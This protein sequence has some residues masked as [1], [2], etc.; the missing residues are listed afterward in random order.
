MAKISVITGTSRGIGKA[1]ALELAQRGLTV[2]AISQNENPLKDLQKLNPDKINIIPAD[3][4]TDAGQAKIQAALQDVKIDYLINNAGIIHPIG[5]LHHASNNA[6]RK[7]FETNLLAPIFLT[8]SLISRFNAEGARILNMTSVAGDEA[9]A[10]I[11]AYCAAKAALNIWTATLKNELP[12][13]IVSADV[14]PGE[15]DTDM[16]NDLRNA[17]IKIF[18]L[19]T[20]F[21]E[22]KKQK[23]LIPA[24]ICAEFLA[25]ILLKTSPKE[26]SNKKWNIYHDYDKPIPQPL[27]KKKLAKKQGETD[28]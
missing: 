12:S 22:A 27:N 28:R 20:E 15:V 17:P 9:V 1:L 2:F 10:G 11:G 16:Q 5:L 18:P 24:S 8:N 23:T 7:L 4:T 3:I 25:N 26:F 6:I 13:Y 14:I 21:Q 19:A